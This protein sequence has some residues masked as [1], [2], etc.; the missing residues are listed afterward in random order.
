MKKT[1]SATGASAR[2]V[3]THLRDAE[4]LQPGEDL[5]F[6]AQ[7]LAFLIHDTPANLISSAMKESHNKFAL[8]KLKASLALLDKVFPE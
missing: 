7:S 2:R 1:H 4:N 8:R 6:L 5:F 3:R